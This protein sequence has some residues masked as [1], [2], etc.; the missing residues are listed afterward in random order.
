M[1]EMDYRPVNKYLPPRLKRDDAASATG[2]AA[3]P[4]TEPEPEGDGRFLR[5][6]DATLSR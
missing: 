5:W 4:G 6:L 1:P 2:S 3:S